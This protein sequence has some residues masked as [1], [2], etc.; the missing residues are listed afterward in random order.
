M[1]FIR[2][3]TPSNAKHDVRAMYERQQAKYGYVPNYAKVFSHRPEIMAHWAN[4]QAGIRQHVD[5]RRFEL[6]TF[7]AA[8][9]LRS[10]YCLLAH[11]AALTEFYSVEEVQL[12]ASDSE[13]GPLSAA[14]GV[15]MTF[16]RKVARDASSI[17]AGD[18]DALRT[19]GFADDEIFDIVAT[20]AARAFFTKTIDALGAE[21]DVAYLEM[22]E[23]LRRSLTVGRPIAFSKAECG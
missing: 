18:V 14:E 5:P 16:A 1:T 4:L 20:A 23:R 21:A 2:T 11:G 8:H 19:H 12:I 10:S 13:V 17:T 9:A 7:A 15:M 3:T 6:V 22:D